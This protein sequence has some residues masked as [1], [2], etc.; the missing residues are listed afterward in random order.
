MG[1]ID[2]R[3]FALISKWSKSQKKGQ[4]EGLTQAGLC[5]SSLLNQAGSK[6]VSLNN[7]FFFQK[8]YEPACF[9]FGHGVPQA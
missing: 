4:V 2:S 8:N 6:I 1:R 9:S 3:G 5:K 7:A